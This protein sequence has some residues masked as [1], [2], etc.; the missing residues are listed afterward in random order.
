MYCLDNPEEVLIKGDF[1]SQTSSTLMVSFD[2]CLNEDN[3]PLSD[4]FFS[5]DDDDYWEDDTDD[6]RRMR[7]RSLYY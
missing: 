5:F 1:S 4:K 3:Y 2:L 7:R 6:R